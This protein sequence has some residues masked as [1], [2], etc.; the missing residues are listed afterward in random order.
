VLRWR[1][2]I[3]VIVLVP[4]IGIMVLDVAWNFGIP[5]SWLAPCG[6]VL[7]LMAT[8]EVISLL[9]SGGHW[10]SASTAYVGTTLVFWA[11]C[12][13]GAWGM[14]SGPTTADRVTWR[15]GWMLVA[16]TL[17]TVSSFAAEMSRFRTPGTAISRV[18][19]TVFVIVYAG[20]L[21]G[22][23]AQLRFFHDSH[24]GMAA[25]VS[26]VFV[27]KISDTGAYAFGKLL[28]R[29]K[30]SPVLSPGKT[31]EG[32]IGGLVSAAVASWL[33]FQFICPL[34]VHNN[35]PVAAWWG[36]SSYGLVVGGAGMMGDLSESLL[37]RDMGRKDS[38]RWIPG[39]GGVL[40]VLDSLLM[41]APAGLFCW[42]VGLVGPITR[43]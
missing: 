6:W 35:G 11:S 10:P 18:A 24:W 25:I 28:G 15:L 19:M 9:R 3:A 21:M 22:F 17:A 14:L 7:T 31:V 8:A 26:L 13:A 2:L 36:W 1:L 42:A 38:S 33:F 34:I 30:M 29:H 32:A 43:A 5:G 27:V 40:D 4:V 20:L 23:L 39:L 16:L 37:K 12:V 41:A